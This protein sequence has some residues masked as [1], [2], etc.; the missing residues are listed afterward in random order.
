M[1][2]VPTDFKRFESLLVQRKNKLRKANGCSG[3]KKKLFR[4]CKSERVFIHND[5]PY[6]LRINEEIENAWIDYVRHCFIQPKL[7]C[8]IR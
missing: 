2:I 7:F 4:A 3:R 8:S 6:S 1:H 5:K